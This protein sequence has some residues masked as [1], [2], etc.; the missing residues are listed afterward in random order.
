[1]NHVGPEPKE[2]PHR[3]KQDADFPRLDPPLKAWLRGMLDTR[4]GLLPAPTKA[5]APA[6]RS[7]S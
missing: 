6:F 5:G 4:F 1:M 2:E 7:Q 3:A